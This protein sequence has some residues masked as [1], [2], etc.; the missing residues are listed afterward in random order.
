MESAA[1]AKPHFVLLPW[2]GTISH[3]IPMA[4]LGCLL[5]SHGA[6]VTIITTPVNAA[7]AQSRVD[8]APAPRSPGAAAI[9]VTAAPFP[10]RGRRPARGL[11]ED[12]PAP[13]SGRG[14]CPRTL[15]TE[16]LYK[17]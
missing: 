15:C 16:Y 3:V 7:I 13:V 10:G 11:R 2:T 14:A 12:G 8:R 5:A 6:E 4:D 1:N 9:T 17:H